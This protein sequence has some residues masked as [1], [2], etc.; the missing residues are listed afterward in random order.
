MRAVATWR[1][2]LVRLQRTVSDGEVGGK[3]LLPDPT[4]LRTSSTVHGYT[5][6]TTN[7]TTAFV[8]ERT[9]GHTTTMDSTWGHVKAFINAYNRNVDY[10]HH[11]AYSCYQRDVGVARHRFVFTSSVTRRPALVSSAHYSVRV[12]IRGCEHETN[13]LGTL[14]VCGGGWVVCTH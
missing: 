6:H 4:C 10:I 9:K 5:H 7:H 2:A 13:F 11:L 14:I 1:R 8:H 12:V 3:H